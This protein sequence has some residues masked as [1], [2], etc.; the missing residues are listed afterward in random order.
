MY[1]LEALGQFIFVAGTNEHND[2]DER[3]LANLGCL[4]KHIAVEAQFLR[5]TGWSIREALG[6]HDE[7]TAAKSKGGK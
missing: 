1:G 3:S 6:L 4:I 7:S 5:E 2:T